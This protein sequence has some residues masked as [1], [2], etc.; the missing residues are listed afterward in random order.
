[1]VSTS[2]RGGAGR[3]RRMGSPSRTFRAFR[4][5][6]RERAI[7]R[8]PRCLRGDFVDFSSERPRPRK[9]TLAASATLSRRPNATRRTEKS[10]GATDPTRPGASMRRIRFPGRS[11]RNRARCARSVRGEDLLRGGTRPSTR[12][13]ICLFSAL[14]TPPGSFFPT[15][16]FPGITKGSTSGAG[17]HHR[18]GASPRRTRLADRIVALSLRITPSSFPP[19]R[20]CA[21]VFLPR[22]RVRVAPGL[23]SRRLLLDRRGERLLGR[24]GRPRNPPPSPGQPRQPLAEGPPG[25]DPG[26]PRRSLRRLDSHRPQ[27]H[28]RGRGVPFRCRRCLALRGHS[29]PLPQLREGRPGLA[30]PDAIRPLSH[31][32]APRGRGADG[33]VQLARGEKGT[34]GFREGGGKRGWVRVA[35]GRHGSGEEHQGERGVRP[36]G[37]RLAGPHLGRR[38]GHAPGQVRTLP[39]VRAL[40]PLLQDRQDPHRRG[41]G[42][43]LL[44]HPRRARRHEGRDGSCW[45]TPPIRRD[46]AGRRPGPRRREDRRGRPAHRPLQGP[47]RRPGRHRRRRP[48]YRLL[49]RRGDRRRLH[50]APLLRRPRVQLLRGRGRR[51]HGH[52]HRRPGR[53]ALDEHAPTGARLGRPRRPSA[54]VR[55]LL[56]HLGRGQA[57]A[58]EATRGDV[59]QPVPIGRVLARRDDQLPRALGVERRD[60]QRDLREGRADRGVRHRSDREEPER[61]R[62]GQAQVGELA[63][64]EEDG[65]GG[66]LGLGPGAA[67]F[68]GGDP[69]GRRGRRQGPRLRL[70]VHCAGQADDGDAAR[71]G[72]ERQDRPGVRLARDLRRPPRRIRGPGDGDAGELLRHRRKA[73]GDA[74]R[75]DL[76]RAGPLEPPRGLRGRVQQGHRGRHPGGRRRR[77][78]PPEVQG[79]DEVRGQ[80]DEGQG[81]E[82][83]PPRPAGPDRRDERA[84]RHQAAVPAG[85]GD[86]GGIGRRR[87]G[88]GRRPVRRAD[89]APEGVLRVDSRGAPRSRGGRQG[90]GQIPKGFERGWKEEGGRRGVRRLG[91][92]RRRRSARLVRRPAHHGARHPRGK[93]QPRLDARGGRQALLRGDRRG[94]RRAAPHRV[95][96]ASLP[97]RVRPRRPHGLGAVQ[98]QGA[99][100]RGLPQPRH[101]PVRVERGSLRGEIGERPRGREGGRARH[102]AGVR[103]R[104]RGGEAVRREQGGEEE[105]VR[106]DRSALEDE[107]VRRAG[108]LREAPADERGG[109][110]ESHREGLRVLGI[111]EDRCWVVRWVDC[112]AWNESKIAG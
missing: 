96:T 18:T 37:P 61:L 104:R 43:P 29:S 65:G 33:A 77:V 10:D 111:G 16:A 103:L 72:D 100:A 47:P 46:L 102:G 101:G 108:V 8:E 98:P 63:A 28:R 73:A 69:R 94:R 7:F 86:G 95:R 5:L 66:H 75:G 30:P 83:L 93:N 76:P 92:A 112:R 60:E 17:R 40:L 12:A 31:G 14:R 26:I 85:H 106:E 1:M 54:A 99:E 107:R 4:E 42:L 32:I 21:G 34:A 13:R 41:E 25:V 15:R 52:H 49:G 88:R 58:V 19:S 56:A 68:R 90:R 78:V 91:R 71:R 81:E 59:V 38:P 70:R 9:A 84:G 44:L 87:E 97:L 109:L 67:Q 39:P 57:E 11:V 35:G 89:G 3:S 48:R 22:S 105:G 24:S 6:A 110:H 20:F 51:V 62:H 74:R 82:P 53:G 36:G 50:L 27:I 55:A 45:N 23:P 2:G 64:L 79:D 80:G